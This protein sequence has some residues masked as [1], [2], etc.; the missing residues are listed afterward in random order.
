MI[1][2]NSVWNARGSEVLEAFFDLVAA[3]SYQK[4]EFSCIFSVNFVQDASHRLVDGDVGC[5]DRL[6]VGVGVFLLE[7]GMRQL[8]SVRNQ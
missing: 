8:E 3:T 5:R 1:V 2:S 7:D 4:A 6:G